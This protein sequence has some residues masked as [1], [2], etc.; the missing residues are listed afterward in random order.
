MSPAPAALLGG[1]LIG[2]AASLLLLLNGR[3]AGITGIVAGL[4]G[5]DALWRVLFVGGMVLAG[6]ASRSPFTFRRAR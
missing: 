2:L 5:R 3:V 6:A 4:A 1:A